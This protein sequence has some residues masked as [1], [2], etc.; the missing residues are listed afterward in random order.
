VWKPYS[1]K[2]LYKGFFHYKFNLEQKCNTTHISPSKTYSDHKSS[3]FK[4]VV[5]NY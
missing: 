4:Y 1:Y 5:W 2:D 3:N